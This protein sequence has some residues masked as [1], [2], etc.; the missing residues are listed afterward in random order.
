VRGRTDGDVS[1]AVQICNFGVEAAARGREHDD[2]RR[3]G[4]E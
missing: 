1:T 4:K 3:A 2:K